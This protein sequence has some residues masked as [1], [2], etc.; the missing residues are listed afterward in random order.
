[1]LSG[2]GRPNYAPPQQLGEEA[3]RGLVMLVATGQLAPAARKE[4]RTVDRDVVGGVLKSTPCFSAP[5]LCFTHS[6]SRSGAPWVAGPDG[7]RASRG[8]RGSARR[9]SRSRRFAGASRRT[10]NADASAAR[11]PYRRWIKKGRTSP[12]ISS[13]SARRATSREHGQ[14]ENLFVRHAVLGARRLNSCR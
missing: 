9:T 1:M 4:R 8:E 7:H 6:P 14:G 11:R 3:R 2:S 10:R 13:S 5:I 12:R